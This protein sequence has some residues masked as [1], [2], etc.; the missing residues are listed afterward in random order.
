MSHLIV[1][2]RPQRQA[3]LIR[4]GLAVLALL[5]AWGLFEFG[6][7]RSG[8]DILAAQELQATYE[9]QVSGMRNE[10]SR[11]REQKAILERST[12]I[13][14]E[15]Y[16][17][18]ETTV[19]GLQDEILELK[20]ELAFYRG[21]VS[22]SDDAKGLDLQSFE[23]SGRGVERVFSYK[24]VLTQILNNSTFATGT[25]ALAVEGMENGETREYPLQQLSNQKG[26]MRFQFRYFQILEGELSLPEG[27][28]PHRV[29][30]TVKPRTKS[31]KQLSQSFDWAV[32]GS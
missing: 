12:R 14:Q 16:K 24:L 3:R 8:F 28:T 23:L 2:A 22:P 26:E 7:Y 25:V 17:Q 21:I 11:L 18:L 5:L 29:N 9:E 19:N 4:M 15:A 31:H 10:I 27:F 6:R 32:Q 20:G 1:K 30:I 13:E